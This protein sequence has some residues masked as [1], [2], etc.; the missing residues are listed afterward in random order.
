MIKSIISGF[1]RSNTNIN[2]VETEASKKLLMMIKA[3]WI[4]TAILSVN[5]LVSINLFVTRFS[6]EKVVE[7]IKWPF[8]LLICTTLYNAFYH[9]AYYILPVAL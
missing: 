4:I 6:S 2:A 8:L 9:V 3:R 1:R 7:L 5:G